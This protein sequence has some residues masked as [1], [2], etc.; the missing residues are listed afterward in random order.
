MK[1]KIKCL[2]IEDD[3]ISSDIL[4]QW[5]KNDRII[6]F[7][8]DIS[9]TLKDGV[10]K[11]NKNRYDIIILDL[12]LPNGKGLEVFKKVYI[13]ALTTPI[14][15]VSGH[16]DM[17]IEA[18]KHGAQDYLIKSKFEGQDLIRS[19][20]Y[21]IVRN[22]NNQLLIQST[23][24]LELLNKTLQYILDEMTEPIWVKDIYNSYI[25]SNKSF[26]IIPEL[27]ID[28]SIKNKVKKPLT[29]KYD[30]E[31]VSYLKCRSFIKEIK[32]NDNIRYFN[33]C[34]SP[35]LDK[36]N[37]LI[38]LMGVATEITD[39]IEKEYE[40]QES[41]NIWKKSR[42]TEIYEIRNLIT[43]SLNLIRDFDRRSSNEFGSR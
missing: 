29:D 24:Q 21:A 34:K 5:L 10:E 32:D 36:E 15:I 11:V 13:N 1:Q 39:I 22:N 33:I 41:V 35:L 18:M 20:K 2:I 23:N 25:F 3:K 42:S 19:V 37:K 26:D 4:Y 43:N 7:D 9:P 28:I 14:I 38:G 12:V 31:V 27:D 6:S 30:L 8:I 16:E 17:A 40:I